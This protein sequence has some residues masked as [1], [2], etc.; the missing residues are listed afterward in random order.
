MVLFIRFVF[1]GK[2]MR[3]AERE[4]GSLWVFVC[5]ICVN[6]RTR[7]DGSVTVVCWM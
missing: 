6:E 3:T 5:L 7:D 1:L 4:D 2:H